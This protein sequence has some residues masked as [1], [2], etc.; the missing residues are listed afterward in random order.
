MTPLIHDI[1]VDTFGLVMAP[2]AW[3]QVH[4][5]TNAKGQTVSPEF[6]SACCWCLDGALK[7]TVALR[8]K[9]G[10]AEYRNTLAAA[11][12]ELAMMILRSGSWWRNKAKKYAMKTVEII[13]A[14]NDSD[15]RVQNNLMGLSKLIPQAA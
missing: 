6:E 11:R 1:L 2:N 14:W 3:C 10:T 13:W 4:E 12:N 15:R 9:L 8:Y 5:A 7:R